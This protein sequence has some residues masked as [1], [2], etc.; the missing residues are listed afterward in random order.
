M[1]HE[2]IFGP[3][4]IVWSLEAD[5]RIWFEFLAGYA[6]YL[7]RRP[8][9]ASS[10][11]RIEVTAEV[12]RDPVG[13][14]PLVDSLIR[15]RRVSGRD[16]VLGPGL[17]RGTYADG[18]CRCT[19]HPVLLRGNGLRVLEHLFYLL[20]HQ[21]VLE[22]DTEPPGRP[23][24]VHSSGALS[25]GRCHAFCGASGLGKSTAAAL[26]R[27]RTLLTDECLALVRGP[28]A[29][30]GYVAFGT[31]INPGLREKRPG[32]AP[33]AGL[34]LLAQAREHDLQEMA[35]IE[36]V[37]LL[38]REIILPLGLLETDLALGMSRALDQALALYRSGL[39][40]RLSF[41]RDAGFWRLLEPSDHHPREGPPSREPA[42]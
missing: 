7:E 10:G 28:G 36:A 41:R 21:A 31:P 29:E 19:I 16:F 25:A 35:R 9:G 23:F 34:Y 37:P 42:P 6:P 40:R 14:A 24:L 22:M 12:V 15:D 32:N 30:G 5:E 17:V 20:F 18:V 33:L 11:P 1:P 3:A 26:S 13:P 4:R 27:P 8:A 2:L 38:T 39:V